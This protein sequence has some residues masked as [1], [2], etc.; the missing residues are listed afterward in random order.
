MS[1]FGANPFDDPLAELMKLRQNGSVEQYQEGF[2][3]LLSRVDLAVPQ[4]IS[5]FLSGLSD[6]IQNAVRMFRPQTLHDAYCLAKLQEATLQ[7]I[8]RRTKLVLDRNVTYTRTLGVGP[9]RLPQATNPSNFQKAGSS[10]PKIELDQ[11]LV[12]GLC[13]PDQGPSVGP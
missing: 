3:S 5:C 1:R 9:R 6:E 2:D 7:S 4:A 10:N 12:W 13:L 8:A 11:L